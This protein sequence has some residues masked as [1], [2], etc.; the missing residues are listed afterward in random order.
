MIPDT[1]PARGPAL[2]LGALPAHHARRDPRRAAVTFPGGALSRERLE[3]NANQRA[4]ALQAMGV[5]QGDLITVAL[6]NGPEFYETTF[7]LWK[8]GAV[9]NAVSAKLPDAELGAIVHLVDP[10]VVLGPEPSRLPGRRVVPGGAAPD[11]GLS[12]E[13]LPEVVAPYWKAMT[14]GGSTGRPKVIVDHAPGLFDPAA[15]ALLQ[16]VDDVL[17]NPG[18]LYH[19]APFIG[20]HWGLFTGAHVVEMSRFDAAEA[21]RLIARHRVN[22]VNLVPT[23]MSRI[24]R[25]PEAERL[26]ADVSSLRVVF[27]MAA[28]CPEWLKSAWIDWLGADRIFE[29][30]GGTERQGATIISGSEWLERRG[31][32]GRVQPGSRLRVLNAEGADCAPGEVGEI[33][34]LPD[35]GRNATYHYLGAEAKAVGEWESLGDLGRLDADGYLYLSDR[36]TDLIVCGGANIYPAEVEGA[37][38]AHPDV[39]CAVAIGLPDADLGQRV[40]AVVECAPGSAPGAEA[41]MAFVSQRLARYKT[42]RSL[43]FVSTPLRDDAGKVRR[44]ALLAERIVH[45]PT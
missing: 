32:V 26:A 9:P 17:L 31:S 1:T 28:A 41:L 19:N 40:H 44:S 16:Q 38:E 30:Y 29:L 2:P 21:L 22:W 39:R 14:S 27:H 23:M 45:P 5:A 3:A 15:P 13:A 4:R 42:P 35:G 37:L 36:R 10:K 20:M 33:H 24:Q 25:L 7:A 11:P 18:P 8:L 43:E 12:A 34:F 6:P